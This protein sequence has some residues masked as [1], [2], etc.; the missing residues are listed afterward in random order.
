M[1]VTYIKQFRPETF[2]RIKCGAPIYMHANCKYMYIR[3]RV[4][5]RKDIIDIATQIQCSLQL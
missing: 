2:D 3:A 4:F 1:N 5:Q